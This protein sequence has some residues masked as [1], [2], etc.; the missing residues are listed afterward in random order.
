MVAAAVPN[1]QSE[2]GDLGAIDVNARRLDPCGYPGLGVTQTRELGIPDS[3]ETLG[4]RLA[5]SLLALL[6]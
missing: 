4:D 3:I 1:T 2:R 5:T 6:P